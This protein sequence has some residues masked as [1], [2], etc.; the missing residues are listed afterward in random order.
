[1]ILVQN[2]P[3]QLNGNSLLKKIIYHFLIM[4]VILIT[5]QVSF[6]QTDSLEVHSIKGKNYYIHIVEKGESLYFIHKK[7]NVPIEV[8]KKENPSVADGLSIGEK[9]F[10]PVKKNITS[11]VKVDANFINHEVKKKQTLYSIAK[12]Y[13]VKQKEII[14]VN[15]ELSEGLKEGVII[16]IPVVNIKKENAS[17][18]DKLTESKYNTHLVKKGETLYALSKL[19]NVPVDSIKAVNN[20]L[21]RGLKIDETIYIPI[22]NQNPR[23][24][25]NGQLSS[26]LQL[27]ETLSLLADSVVKKPLY[28]IGLMLPFYLDENDEMV[29]N[30]SA[31]EEKRIDPRSKFAL[32]FYNGFL[33]ALDSLTSDSLKFKLYVYDTKGKDSV[34]TKNLLLK[35]EFKT[36]DLIVGP[37]YKSNFKQVATF[38]KEHQIPITSPVKLSNK[39]LL[40]NEYVFKAIPSKSTTLN[41][42]VTLTIDSF[43]TENLMALEYSKSKE[44]SLIPLYSKMYNNRILETEDTIL[45]SP[46]KILSISNNYSEITANLKMNKNNVIFIPVTDKTY[47]TNLFSY[48]VTTLNKRDYKDYK[49]TIIGQEEWLNYDNI[50][51]EYFQRLNVYIPTYQH[52]NYSDSL[53][54]NIIEKYVERTETYPS[55]NSLLGYDLA[56]FF[57]TCFTT[58]GTLFNQEMA[59]EIKKG[60]SLKLEFKKTGIESGFENTSSCI[61]KF[62]D[63]ILKRVY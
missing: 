38:A 20:G 41:Q 30:R 53:S 43:K 46:I 2:H 16:K 52:V 15:P 47:I 51:L 11:G 29:Q 27:E 36:F 6:A 17:E 63:Y 7:F 35:E 5:T 49:M 18:A 19:Y 48:L 9:I 3:L 42:I 26:Q 22:Q 59:P 54:E 56:Y 10:V 60:V 37:L 12:I 40:G 1:M 45:Y 50:D 4:V 33:M 34:T 39:I 8:I 55:N 62:D 23:V 58:Y 32:D 28:N 14:A 44:K 13:K 21:K 24:L 25:I 61:L 57:G 31:F